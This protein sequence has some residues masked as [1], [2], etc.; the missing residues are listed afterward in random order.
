M[1][2]FKQY[3][4]EDWKRAALMGGATVAA[5]AA[6]GALIGLGALPGGIIAGLHYAYRDM[7]DDLSKKPGDWEYGKAKKEVKRYGRSYNTRTKVA[8]A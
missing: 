1:K 5:G 6:T 7:K 8:T 2:T 4:E 3:V